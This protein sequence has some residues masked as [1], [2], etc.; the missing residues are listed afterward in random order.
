MRALIKT[1]KLNTKMI[2]VNDIYYHDAG[3]FFQITIPFPDQWTYI[4][5][6]RK[7]V[8]EIQTC[9]L[10]NGYYDF[11]KFETSGKSFLKY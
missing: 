11:R 5:V 9:F 3:N 8:E 2:T 10:K 1:D 7:E 6:D 4:K